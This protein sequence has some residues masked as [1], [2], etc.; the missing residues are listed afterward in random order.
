LQS[1]EALGDPLGSPHVRQTVEPIAE[2]RRLTNFDHLASIG[3]TKRD[4]LRRVQYFQRG[5]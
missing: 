2:S 3:S 4:S 1:D 5:R